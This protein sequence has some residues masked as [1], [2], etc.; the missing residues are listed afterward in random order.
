MV[1][2]GVVCAL[3]PPA[4]SQWDD[5]TV[6]HDRP[7]SSFSCVSKL[8]TLV[9]VSSVHVQSVHTVSCT[10]FVAQLQRKTRILH[11][12]CP[13]HGRFFVSQLCQI[14]IGSID[15]LKIDTK[16]GRGCD[17]ELPSSLLICRFVYMGA[18][19]SWTP[20]HRDVF[21]SYS[22]SGKGFYR[23]TFRTHSQIALLRDLEGVSL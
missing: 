5:L 16:G 22:W 20:L 9:C 23:A 3:Q 10:V 7:L 1:Y 11:V 2:H 6:E 13:F 15:Y 21:R 18:T 17:F 12:L 4:E 8:P 14:L 19:H